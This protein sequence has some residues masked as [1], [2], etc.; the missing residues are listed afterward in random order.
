MSHPSNR[1]TL[2]LLAGAFLF[3]G[4]LYLVVWVALPD[5]TNVA[6]YF[7]NMGEEGRWIFLG[8]AC[9]AASASMPRQFISIAAGMIFGWIEGLILCSLAVM[10]GNAVQFAFSRLMLRP[11]CQRRFVTKVGAFDRFVSLGPFRMVLMMRLLPAGNS[12]LINL[13]AGASSISMLVFLAASYI[14]QLPQ[15]II[16][17]LAGS[18]LTVDPVLR[19]SVAAVLLI[20]SLS[21]GVG[22]YRR[23]K[24]KGLL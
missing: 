12:G 1:K 9:L 22:L 24:S 8:V 5:V 2:W 19:L 18:G 21:L 16:F 17:A 10:C 3:F 15:N 6:A 7:R 23:Y 4:I 13:A 11:V 20:I 14:G